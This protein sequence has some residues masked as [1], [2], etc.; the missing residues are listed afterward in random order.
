MARVQAWFAA[1]LSHEWVLK[2]L[3]AAAIAIIGL[4]LARVLARAL[5]RLMLR[6]QVEETL[7]SFLR[8][9]AYSA[10]VVVAMIAALDF[11]GVPTT[12]LLAV[13]GAAGLAIGLALK[14]S[15]AN[16]ASG[17]MLI[18]LHP[19]RKGDQV[20]IAGHEGVVDQ[21]RIF[22]T[23]LVTGDNRTI[24]LPN[25]QITSAPITNFTQ[26][27]DR[28]VDIPVGIAYG[29]DIALARSTLL[30]VAA[31]NKLVKSE[32]AAAVV[33]TELAES[34]V[35]LQLR[36]WAF[37]PDHGTVKT[38]LTE[39]VYSRFGQVGISIPYPQRDLHVYHHDAEGRP[40]AQLTAAVQDGD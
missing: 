24:I 10:A 8:N 25:S 13:V 5:E 36:V 39:A 1:A 9:V 40:L 32:P 34:S 31:A 18:V 16:I 11:A 4:W 20:Q 23:L 14:D 27:G 38:E 19:F 7:R 2:L 15:L 26:R 30:A 28:R 22:Q 35:N 3:T 37:A 17:V 29:D 21:V 12:S 33:V 6:F